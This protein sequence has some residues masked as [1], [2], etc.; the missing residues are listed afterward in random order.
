[1][2]GIAIVGMACRFPDASSPAE[3]W[4]NV[5][6]GR[7]SFRRLPDERL[8]AQDYLADDPA[9]DDRTYSVRAAVLDGWTF[10]RVRF[11]VSGPT[12]RSTDLA[13]WLALEVVADA[14]ADAGYPGGDGLARKRTL[15]V[16]GNTLTGEFSR[17]NALRLRW[18][19]VRRVVAAALEREGQSEDH[20]TRFLA[21][22]ERDFK[23]PFAPVGEDTLAG[24]LS[25]TIAGRICNVFDF[26]G[27]GYTVDGACASSLLAVCTA[28]D[29]LERG[30]A[31]VALAGGVDLSLDPFEL[32]GFAK[33]GAL[34]HEEMRI[35]DAGSQGFWPGEG[36]GFV[37]LRRL[38]DAV[39]DGSEGEVVLRGWG[40]SADGTG[41][42]TRPEVEGQAL[43]VGRTYERAGFGIDTVSYFEGHGTG[44]GVGD[45]TELA[46]LDAARRE[47]GATAAAVIGSIKANIGHTKAAAGIAGLIKAALVVREEL[48]PPTTGCVEP[49]PRLLE[50]GATLRVSREPEL[51][52]ERAAIRAA[53]SAMGFGGINAHAVLERVAPR[54]RTLLQP[55]ECRSGGSAQDAELFLFGGSADA[56]AADVSAV[57]RE[58]DALS[59]GELG[60]V[61]AMLARRLPT[62]ACEV[63]AAVVAGR[64]DE[65]AANLRALADALAADVASV[66]DADHGLAVG[67]APAARLGLVFTGQG[68]PAPADGGALGRMFGVVRDV[69][70]RARL[71]PSA[72]RVDT[73]VAQPAIVT[74]SVAGA[75]LLRHLAIEA[76][77]AVGHSLG[78]LAALAWA[79]AIA[80]DDAIAVAGARG[81]AMADCGGPPS[82]M[83]TL[84]SDRPTV[85]RLTAGTAAVVA[86]VNGRRRI[87]V[88]GAE[89]DVAEVMARARRESIAAAR[90]RVSHAFHS[91]LVAGAAGPLRESLSAVTLR[92]LARRVVSTVTGAEIEP[93]DDVV[94]LLERQVTAPVLFADALTAAATEVD[95][96]V[97]VGPGDVLTTLAR[98][99]VDTPVVPLHVGG[100]SLKQPLFAIGT[101]FAL[102]VSCDVGPLFARRATLPFELGRQR[103]FLVSPCEAAP[104]DDGG[105]VVVAQALPAD[106]SAA[107]GSL[108]I[109]R[110]L[111]ASR[112]ELPIDSVQPR[113][114]L[115]GD[116]HLSSIAVA[117]LAAAAARQL[118]VAA[119]EAP[120]ELATA[121]VAELA[122]ALGRIATVA[123]EVQPTFPVGVGAWIRPFESV[124]V[125]RDGPV[126]QA[127]A[128][129]WHVVGPPGHG[130]VA[131]A[132]AAFEGGAGE[133][134]I[135]LV[136]PADAR[137]EAP[138]LVLAADR[139]VRARDARRFA[140]LEEEAAGA[141]F[142]RVLWAERR[143]D[144][145]V[146]RGGAEALLNQGRGE[147]ETTH[148]YREVV[149]GADGIRRVPVLRP[150]ELRRTAWPLAPGDVLLVSGGGKGIGFE[151]AFALAQAHDL[152]IAVVGRSDP[153]DDEELAAT[154]ARYTS[155]GIRHEYVRADVT[156]A[157]GIATAVAAVETEL[158]PV[159]GILHSAGVNEPALLDDLDVEAFD[160]TVR[161]KLGGLESLLA[162]VG[163]HRLKLVVAFGSV[164]ARV[165]VRGEAHYSLANQWLSDRLVQLAADNAGCR[166]LAVEWSIWS[167]AGMGEKLGAVGSLAQ[168]G[169]TAIPVAEGVRLLDELLCSDAPPRVVVSGRLGR[170]STVEFERR[171]APLLRFVQRPLVEYP[172][173]E[174]VADT[175]ISLA[176]DPYLGDHVLDR[177]MLLPAVV[178]LE[179]MAQAAAV[180]A[181][182]DAVAVCEDVELARPVT[183]PPDASRTIRVAA[184]R[185]RDGAVDVVLR[186]D[187]T[188]FAA[189]HFRCTFCPNAVRADT[190]ARSSPPIDR[191]ALEPADVYETLLFHGRRFRRLRGYLELTAK[192]CQVEI[193]ARADEQWFSELLPQQL[194]LGD[195]GARDAIIHSLQACIPHARVLPVA[196]ERVSR[197][198]TLDGVVRVEARERRSD[199]DSYT[200]D[201]DVLDADGELCEEWRGLRLQR[202]QT[203]LAPTQWP[204]ALLVP[205]LERRIGELAGARVGVA[206][207]GRATRDTCVTDTAIATAVGR[208]VYVE[209]RRD[210]RPFTNGVTVSAAHIDGYT[211]AV[212]GAGGV[213]CDIETAADRSWRDLLGAQRMILAS[214]IA[215]DLH[216]DFAGSAARV[217]AAAECAR[218][219]GQPSP[220]SLAL[221]S[222]TPDRW[223]VLRAG[224]SPVATYVGHVAG[225]EPEVAF[226]VLVEETP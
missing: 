44:T 114:R 210:G 1:V 12:F 208:P 186:S 147:A 193:D 36:S 61:A 83:A 185:R 77:V 89:A 93:D 214:R 135:V 50:H 178:G 107:G 62:G 162:A 191:V 205:Y 195:I 212:A 41:G 90:L 121:T 64:P 20:R 6:A 192:S 171:D 199:G 4:R 226:A 109:V 5:L 22:L 126:G 33:V 158:G 68:A 149:F 211:L 183:V 184:L 112:T 51:F 209:R 58:A 224:R 15:V 143:L 116:L 129:A 55:D 34:A 19:Y 75:A 218:K 136:L 14:L 138:A 159:V 156:D 53:V 172:G 35:Y 63:R 110:A 25:N 108:D 38:E 120:S 194:L 74:A 24:G 160:A 47:A 219:A 32:V 181:G 146:V 59:L 174:L 142:A 102:G 115:L 84:G 170:P 179:A 176:T 78:E 91:P 130:L 113:A 46:T 133:A 175:E 17:A 222:A 103:A 45:A 223:A 10:D 177:V 21:D 86:A 155:A 122:E 73:A 96:F 188:D 150:L 111:V 66:V 101:L 131:R 9:A 85:E 140:L 79:E 11:N 221:V 100:S 18:P 105:S 37:V 30:D 167:G 49:H 27:G 217:W 117:E 157:D 169:I 16:V 95:V 225:I 3:L 144:C 220:E 197:L 148:G 154:L 164:L 141:A 180:L 8:R 198:R 52:P 200:W 215:A 207:V 152:A 190:P 166:C 168:A 92:P 81:R 67:G 48:V 2:S 76:D 189:D 125:A 87:V 119:P 151:C 54:R 202:M 106:A 99:V 43:A 80:P 139:E 7:R 216:E 196:V 104:P 137:A 40:V 57:L 98:D 173:V 128:T 203:S 72:D 187:E 31:D 29:A 118:G 39:R 69:Y 165:G 65:L 42:I 88:S 127:S 23:A 163:V 13:H 82:A 213:A 132:R 201:L 123:G 94:A 26:K 204:P 145:C 182:V 153:A 206:L 56:V 60:D 70:D 124:L 161:P 28:A 134:G 71:D 97:E